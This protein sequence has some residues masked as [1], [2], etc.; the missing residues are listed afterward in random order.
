VTT[1]GQ[2]SL[3]NGTLQRKRTVYRALPT[4]PAPRGKGIRYTT[5]ASAHMFWGRCWY[6]WNNPGDKV[7]LRRRTVHEGRLSAV[8]PFVSL[9]PV[10]TGNARARRPGLRS[11]SDLA[12]L[13][14]CGE[15]GRSFRISG[16]VAGRRSTQSRL[17]SSRLPP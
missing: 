10:A 14:N 5:S 4:T 13:K 17:P 1:D 15:P 6:V 11:G 8:N 9:W 16:R 7:I 2:V 12:R 3:S